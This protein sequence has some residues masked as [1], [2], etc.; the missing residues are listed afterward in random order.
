[1]RTFIASLLAVSA[2]AAQKSS[3]SYDYSDGGASWKGDSNYANNICGMV[4]S[5]EQSPIDLD[6]STATENADLSITMTGYGRH[7]KPERSTSE[8]GK[9]QYM[10]TN[11]LVG[12]AEEVTKGA[13]LVRRG[14]ADSLKSFNPVQ[15]HFHTPSEHTVDGKLMDAEIHIVH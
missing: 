4:S 13:E 11:W 3:G 6:S 9:T 5:M 8:D 7:S 15:Y 2:L 14:P 12:L 1:M 10:P